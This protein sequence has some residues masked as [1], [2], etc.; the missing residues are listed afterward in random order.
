MSL[1]F[2]DSLHDIG[3]TKVP[4]SILNKPGRL[5]DEEFS[6]MKKHSVFGYHMIKERNEFNEEI[7]MAVLQH[8]EKLN[9]S[10]YPLGF[11]PERLLLMHAYSPYLTYMMLL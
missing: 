6:I 10:G 4:L 1:V 3:K 7:C 2:Q 9:G 5:T 11:P 8:H